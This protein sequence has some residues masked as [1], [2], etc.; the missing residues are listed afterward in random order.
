MSAWSRAAGKARKTDWWSVAGEL[1]I[2]ILGILIA[3]QLDRWSEG[4]RGAK[5]RSAYLQRL[6][7]ES[8]A[9][10]AALTRLSGQFD[11]VTEE[12]GIMTAAVGDPAR[13]AALR[14]T[15]DRAC[16]ALQMPAARLQTAALEEIGNPAALQLVADP[17]LRRLIHIAAGET[18]YADR[19]IE[20]FR[21]TFQRFGERFDPHAIWSVDAA[22][23]EI[24]CRVDFEALARE[25][26]AGTLLA[27][28][29]RD[30]LV[31]GGIHAAQIEAQRA[32]GRRAACLLRDDCR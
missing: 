16:R 26:G 31:F 27:R 25:P 29:H 30:R 32:V 12:V 11:D 13:R 19:Q 15:G 7:E 10:V 3:F 17:T 28:I 4:W 9:N 6:I 2:V 20:Y 22:T 5:D 23:R 21:D 1:V 18:R 24:G 14:F 8:D